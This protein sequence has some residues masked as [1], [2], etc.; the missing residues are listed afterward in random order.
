[1][2]SVERESWATTSS[3]EKKKK[4]KH[5]FSSLLL[6]SK[7]SIA[8]G[9][10][11]LSEHMA[12]WRRLG[13]SEENRE[14]NEAH[15][16]T[17][18]LLPKGFSNFFVS[19]RSHVPFFLNLHLTISWKYFCEKRKWLQIYVYATALWCVSILSQLSG[20]T[21]RARKRTARE[22]WKVTQSRKTECFMGEKCRDSSA[23]KCIVCFKKYG[24][25]MT[26]EVL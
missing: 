7:L 6:F 14:Q 21:E 19:K 26:L 23:I 4:K 24:L 9:G 17:Y 1:M 22:W 12:R 11:E 18:V 16:D 10:S 15:D 8:S 5:I 13:K 25:W 2:K 3:K 20:F